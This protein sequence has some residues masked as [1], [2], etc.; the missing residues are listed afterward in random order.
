MSR[1]C[2]IKPRMLSA[3]Q[4]E[5]AKPVVA[6]G[7]DGWGSGRGGRP[8]RRIRES[9]LVRDNYTCCNCGVVT[10]D[11]EVDHIINVAVGGTD[12]E[13]NLQALCVTCH[14]AKTAAES[15]AGS[16]R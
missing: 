10:L 1:L 6:E 7:A 2:T 4:R 12:D 13:Q 16:G 5:M 15:A 11:L 8:W 14:K 9:I 3:P